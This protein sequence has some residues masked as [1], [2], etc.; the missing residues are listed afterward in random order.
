MHQHDIDH[1]MLFDL[2]NIKI[3]VGWAG[4]NNYRIMKRE[5]RLR[6]LRTFIK[7]H[8]VLSPDFFV[9][10]TKKLLKWTAEMHEFSIILGDHKTMLEVE[11]LVSQ[12]PNFIESNTSSMCSFELN[13]SNQSEC[14][15]S[16]GKNLNNVLMCLEVDWSDPDSTNEQILQYSRAIKQVKIIQKKIRFLRYLYAT[17]INGYVDHEKLEGLRTRI[18][19]MAN[20]VI[21]FCRAS[22]KYV[23]FKYNGDEDDDDSEDYN[24]EDEDEDDDENSEDEN[25]DED[26]NSEDEDEDESEDEDD[27]LNKPP[28]LLCL[29]ALVE[30][31]MKKIFLSELKASKFTRSRTFKDKKLPKGF[32]HHLQC[33]LM[34]L[35]N[36]KLESFP[37]HVSS[38]NID[39]AIEFLLFFLGNVPNHNING[40]WL[41]EVLEEVGAIV[42]DILYAIQKLLLSSITKDDTKEI[43]LG[44][45]LIS[46]K[47]ENLKAQV[48]ERYYKSFKFIPS[49]FPTVGG[50]SFV[51][52]LLRKLNEMQLKSEV[53]V[54]SIMKPHICVIEKEFSSLTSTFREHEVLKDLQRSIINLAYEA[55]VAIDS[56]LVQHNVLWHLF[57]SLP[58]IIKEIKH[59]NAEVN[60]MWSENLSLKSCHVVDPSEHLPTQHSN[61][62]N[63][64]EMVGFE[65][66]AEKLIQYLTRGT[67]EQDVIP[68]VGMGGQGK[69]TIA[70][71]LYNDNIIVSHFD[72]RAWCIVSQR[73]N[74][75]GI[76]QE[77]F[78]QVTGSKDNGDEVGELAHKLK[79]SLTGK[80]YLIV[81]DDMWD[82]MAWDELRLCFPDGNRSR[83]VITTRLEKV[84]TH[85]MNHTD[86]YFLPFLTP[87]E[88]SQLLQKKV[89][90]REGFPPELEDVSLAVAKRCKG[91]PLVVVLVAGIIKK[92]KM[93][94]SWWHEVKK[95]LLSYLDESEGY[96]LSTMKLS[97]DNLPDYLR[98][99]LLYMGMFP[100]DARIPVSK[101][102][103]LWI[104][105]GFV[106]NIDSGISM[107]EAAEGYLMDLVRSNVVMASRR[108]YNG[109]V[110]YC[111]VHDVVLHFCLRKSREEKFMLPVK[112]HYI[113][114]QP[115][116]WMGSRVVFS[117]SEEL[118]K[119]ATLGFNTRMPFHHHL[120]SL[121]TTNRGR[122]YNWNPFPQVSEVKLLKVLDL[123]SLDVENL[124]SATLKPLIHL[125]YLSAR[126]Y[127]FHFHPESL[128]PHLETLIVH[129]LSLLPASFWEME[130]LRHFDLTL[131]EF[132]LKNNKQQIF[133]EYSK[134]EN[135]RIF[136]KVEFSIYQADSANVLFQ[137]IPN[138]QELNITFVGDLYSPGIRVKL[139][140][141]TQL[142][143]LHLSVKFSKVEPELL[144]PSKLRKLEL[145]SAR[146]GSMISVIAGLPNLE[147]LQLTDLH[148][149][150][151]KKWCQGVAFHNLKF[152]KLAWLDISEW[153]AS[154][155]SFPQLETLVI[156]GCDKLK[157]IP[158]S[159][160]DIPTLQQIKLLN[161]MNK[162]LEASAVNIKE[163]VSNIEGCDRIDISIGD[164]WG[165]LKHL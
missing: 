81:L 36:K 124:S 74:R 64:E 54:G 98:P 15:D 39:V 136:K 21:Q 85:V 93:K 133:E 88:S 29:I 37:N 92:K 156:K 35:R 129:G 141:L 139:E 14:M 153:D 161:C 108:R 114:F 103:N 11:R 128:L 97:Y 158:F 140:H 56:I 144:L 46:E 73:Y 7:Y 52:S 95:S 104:A 75:R 57:F 3:G 65:I 122:F 16:L 50:L 165:N 96:G 89:F 127:R 132:D 82:C 59:I 28:Y 150:Q 17:E 72:V 146:I 116:D 61:P 8:H 70:R 45:I 80:R 83:I 66:A 2:S 123:S 4:F 155:D 23:V 68:I 47:T 90:P 87:E 143:I 91:L 55:E 126:T 162:S 30:L 115:F 49:Q 31:E 159:F 25:E 145:S 135:L 69:T 33:L 137:R 43:N 119:F 67:S 63:D 148:F 13:D 76:L 86:P 120:R 6:F 131:A 157:A 118:N 38:R 101:L 53:S 26:D 9:K 78:S 160:V 71:K 62:V 164:K 151:S 100:E 20:D 10:I 27:I 142:Q 12:L 163:E 121:I 99:C 102:I 40:K 154:E 110:K 109:M 107:E 106:Q 84:S 41:N 149:I 48:E 60:K 24:G 117:F 34:Y 130:K 105:E 125:K 112:G 22:V 18:Q 111:Q 79:K 77:I 152:L 5:M 94:E 42:G 44:A 113:Q 138:L 147:Y 58:T 51:D 1:H 134:L 19:F 32:P